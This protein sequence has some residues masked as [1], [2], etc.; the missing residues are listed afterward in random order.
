LRKKIVKTVGQEALE[1]VLFEL[2]IGVLLLKNNLRVEVEP[3]GRKGPDLRAHFGGHDTYIEAKKLQHDA[4]AKHLWASE[5]NW[6]RVRTES[7]L[8][9]SAWGLYERYL[10]LQRK[11]ALLR[12]FGYDYESLRFTLTGGSSNRRISP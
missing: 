2:E 1:A 9:K 11:I 5:G 6:V 8:D 12:N 4:E 10:I 7:K 3:L